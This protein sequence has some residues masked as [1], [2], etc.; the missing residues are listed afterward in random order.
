MNMDEVNA[1]VAETMDFLEV[2]M[3]E[4]SIYI[5]TKADT[6]IYEVITSHLERL[7]GYPEYSNYN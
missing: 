2:S 6:E 4:Y 1:V 7:A 3:K 5:D